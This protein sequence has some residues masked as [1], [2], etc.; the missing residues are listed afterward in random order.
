MRELVGAILVGVLGA[1]S[2]AAQEWSGGRGADL[3][4]GSPRAARPLNEIGVDAFF[5]IGQRL[6]FGAKFANIDTLPSSP[7]SVPSDFSAGNR[8]YYRHLLP[9]GGGVRLGLGPELVYEYPAEGEDEWSMA[10]GPG[11][12]SAVERVRFSAGAMFGVFASGGLTYLSPGREFLLRGEVALG[13]MNADVEVD[14][15]AD[16]NV[17]PLVLASGQ[18]DGNGFQAAARLGLTLG[19]NF[20]TPWQRQRWG[21]GRRT[22]LL[23]MRFHVGY[24]WV[25]PLEI[26]WDPTLSSSTGPI[27]YQMGRVY[28]RMSGWIVALGAVITF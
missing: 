4:T 14:Y 13:G 1:R 2:A 7:V 22:Q 5:P 19:F 18:G 21:E 17:P 27:A 15:E 6:R 20:P 3:G 24:L 11:F 28:Y 26:E 16:V 25:D 8:W 10:P 23:G 12:A 9:I